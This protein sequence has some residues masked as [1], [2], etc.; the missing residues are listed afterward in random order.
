MPQLEVHTPW[1]KASRRPAVLGA[2]GK[3]KYPSR[4]TRIR[5]RKRTPET[6]LPLRAEVAERALADWPVPGLLPR[7]ARCIV[8]TSHANPQK[9][10]A[11]ARVLFQ[12]RGPQHCRGPG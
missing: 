9:R 11:G 4:H 10:E 12:A 8:E 5:R 1:R 2:K 6:S 7:G 3:R